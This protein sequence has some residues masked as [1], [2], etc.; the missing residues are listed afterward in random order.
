MLRFVLAY[1]RTRT[2]YG[3][4]GVVVANE[5]QRGPAVGSLPDQMRQ[6]DQRRDLTADP[7]PSTP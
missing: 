2:E 6:V 5:L 7:Q 3:H 4:D 1:A